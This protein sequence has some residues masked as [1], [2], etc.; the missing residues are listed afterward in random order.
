[1]SGMSG[2]NGQGLGERERSTLDRLLE[3]KSDGFR[4]KVLDVV[5][6]NGWDVNEPSF[7]ILLATGQMQ[8]LLEEFP[9]QFEA[10][11]TRLLERQR[12]VFNEQRQFWKSQGA[13]IRDYLRGVEATGSQLVAG[14][15]DEVRELRGFAQGQRAQLKQDVQEVLGL[16]NTEKEQLLE[17][18]RSQMKVGQKHYFAAVQAQAKTLVEES[19]KRWRL[20][21]FR[22]AG[23]IAGIV[24]AVVFLMGLGAGMKLHQGFVRGDEIFQWGQRMWSWNQAQFL[25]CEKQER[26]TCNFHIV[27]PDR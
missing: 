22:E 9:E 24:G 15:S 27:E 20:E 17:E 11:F 6:R 25:E 5:V 21:F 16:A 8:V 19:G 10:L 3:G 14:V 12:Q 7:M 26:T 23:V 18:V 2:G 4:A 13:E 1:M